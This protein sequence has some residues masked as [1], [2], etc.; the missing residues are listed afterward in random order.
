M[1]AIK[2]LWWSGSLGHSPPSSK[3]AAAPPAPLRYFFTT[4]HTSCVSLFYS[5]PSPTAPARL[6]AFNRVLRDREAT[7]R[8]R[9]RLLKIRAPAAE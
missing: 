5:S 7:L 8:W 1:L 4:R 9:P 2:R 3:T 6:G